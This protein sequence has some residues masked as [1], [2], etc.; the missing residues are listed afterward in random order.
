MCIFELHLNQ[1]FI[2]RLKAGKLGDKSE[3]EIQK[4]L[5]QI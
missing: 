4:K 5:K 3:E 2:S 1:S